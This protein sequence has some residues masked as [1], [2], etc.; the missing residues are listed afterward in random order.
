MIKKLKLYISNPKH[1]AVGLCFLL[2]STLFAL[3]ITRIPEVK[4]TLGLSEGDLG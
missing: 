1:M 4:N 2:L 3:W